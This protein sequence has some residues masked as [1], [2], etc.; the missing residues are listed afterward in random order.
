MLAVLLTESRTGQPD[1]SALRF[2]VTETELA[3]LAGSTLNVGIK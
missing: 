1:P 3:V 2:Q